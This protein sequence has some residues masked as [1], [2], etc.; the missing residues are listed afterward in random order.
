MNV[1]RVTVLSSGPTDEELINFRDFLDVNNNG[2]LNI[3]AD[4]FPVIYN[5]DRP[6]IEGIVYGTQQPINEVMTELP[7][8]RKCYMIWVEYTDENGQERRIYSNIV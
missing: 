5:M 4:G 1:N 8:G 6:E 7:A 2:P 3:G